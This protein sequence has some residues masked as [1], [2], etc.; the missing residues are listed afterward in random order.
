MTDR[1]RRYPPIFGLEVAPARPRL[2]KPGMSAL[3]SFGESIWT[4]SGGAVTSAGFRYPTRMAVARLANGALWVWSPVAL[5]A[6]VRAGVDALG[7]VAHIVAPNSL[8][9]VFLP[10]WKSAYPR[11]HVY[12][13]PGLRARRKDIA[14]DADLTEAPPA[15]WAGEIDQAVVRGNVITTEVVF[16]H[17]ASGTVL[18]TDIL[19]NFP[20]GWFKGWRAVIAKMDRMLEPMPAV[21]RKFRVAFTDRKAARVSVAKILDWPAQQVL[22]AHGDPV[23][24][25]GAGFLKEAF[26]WL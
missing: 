20:P 9:H 17:R 12:A 8:H 2:H 3:E 1:R 6:D 25:N 10:E 23:R 21:P 19:Q 18:F 22:M 4:A 16:F 7:E 14:F 26:A 15:A 24:A 11:A 13:A 5:S